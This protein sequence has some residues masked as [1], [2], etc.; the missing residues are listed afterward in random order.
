MTSRI[1]L[2]IFCSLMAVGAY[3][4]T[5]KHALD[6]AGTYTG[7]CPDEAGEVLLRLTLEYDHTFTKE[8]I[9]DTT[10]QDISGTL[11]WFDDGLRIRLIGPD[12]TTVL[13]AH[14]GENRLFLLTDAGEHHAPSLWE[15]PSLEKEL[16]QDSTLPE[17]TQ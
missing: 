2:L 10:Q 11:E 16:P 17:C 12:T 5:S 13:S 6:W 1:L 9:T 7:T 3:P 8:R 14:V 4:H 15:H